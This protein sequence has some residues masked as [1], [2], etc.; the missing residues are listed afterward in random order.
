MSSTAEMHVAGLKTGVR[1]VSAS[2][3]S[4]VKK[5]TMITVVPIMTNLIDSILP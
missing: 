1:S 3:R 5:G 4:N 2:N